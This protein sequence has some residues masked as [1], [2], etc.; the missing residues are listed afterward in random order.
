MKAA[1]I[2]LGSELL[3]ITKLDKN[4]L[5]ITAELEHFGVKLLGKSI[6][7]DDE[8]TIGD[9]LKHWITH[10]DMI[11]ITGGLGPTT[12]DVTRD[13]VAEALGKALTPNPILEEQ[14]CRRFTS[15]GR[16]MADIN[17]NKP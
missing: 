1:I 15:M 14:I 8:K 2:A 11:I 9:T 5:H 16:Q 4:S 17:R 12:D 10:T 13:A 3:G 7:G 6:I